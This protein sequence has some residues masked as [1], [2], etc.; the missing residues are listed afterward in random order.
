[1]AWPFVVHASPKQ[2]E[3]TKQEINKVFKANNLNITIE[4]NKKLYIS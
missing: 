2:I 1:M 4:A 3:K